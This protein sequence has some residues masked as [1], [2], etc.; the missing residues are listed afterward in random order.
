[1]TGEKTGPRVAD[2]VLGVLVLCA[3]ALLIVLI[4]LRLRYGVD[5]RDEAYYSVL[6]YRF[7]LGDRPFV[8]EM[9][10][11]QLP[12]LLVYPFVKTYVALTGGSAGIVLF[13]RVMWVFF[14]TALAATAFAFLRTLMRWQPALLASL[15][16]FVTVPYNIPSLSYNTMGMG[17]LAIGMLLGAWATVNGRG[18]RWLIGAGLAHGLAVV[19]YPTLVVALPAYAAVLIVLYRRR[20]AGALAAYLGGAAPVGA[21][22]AALMLRSGLGNVNA[23]WRY[24][25]SLSGYGGGGHKYAWILTQAAGFF[26]QQPLLLAAVAVSIL[27]LVA[28]RRRGAVALLLPAIVL[29]PVHGFWPYARGLCAITL[30]GVVGVFIGLCLVR[31]EKARRLWLWGIL[32]AL[33]AGAVTAYTSTNGFINGGIGFFPAVFATAGLLGLAAAHFVPADDAGSVNEQLALARGRGGAAAT[34]AL[35][36]VLALLVFGFCSNQYYSVYRAPNTTQLTAMVPGGPFAGLYTL[37]STQ[38]YEEQLR[39]DIQTYVPRDAFVLFFNDYPAP[40]LMTSARPAAQALWLSRSDDRL[41]PQANPITRWWRTTG[42]YPDVAFRFMNAR[43]GK[44]PVVAAYIAAP[45]Y[46]LVLKR[47]YYEVWV[48]QGWDGR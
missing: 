41:R 14:A 35:S 12:A 26:P 20:A 24:T 8:D 32:P 33:V 43:Y 2:I 10:L 34:W 45:R 39:S 21:L 47:T 48:R 4:S 25:S 37:E 16:A 13:L 9:N 22:L 42:R 15:L 11:L 29:F 3:V 30:V 7:A 46:R 17:F 28:V 19:A 23:A 36:A 31:E 44:Y 40:Y 18:R 5:L 38:R 27:A 6:P 1:V